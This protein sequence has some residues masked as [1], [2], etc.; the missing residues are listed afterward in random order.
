MRKGEL[1]RLRPG[2][3]EALGK[4]NQGWWLSEAPSSKGPVYHLRSIAGGEM[5]LN[6]WIGRWLRRKEL[7][8]RAEMGLLTYDGRRLAEAYG[9]RW[10]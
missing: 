2:Q 10:F 3:R 4:L 6:G 7:V 5:R 1:P 9:A 8:T